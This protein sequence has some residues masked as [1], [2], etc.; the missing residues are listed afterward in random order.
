MG[1]VLSARM[2]F[3][4]SGRS[5]GTALVTFE[6]RMDAYAAMDKFHNVPLDGLPM[7]IKVNRQTPVLHFHELEGGRLARTGPADTA[8]RWEHDKFRPDRG[9]KSPADAA[10]LDDDLEAYMMQRDPPTQIGE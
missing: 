5:N 7:R 1:K 8:D 4:R 10:M 9:R 3:D 6:D 2:E